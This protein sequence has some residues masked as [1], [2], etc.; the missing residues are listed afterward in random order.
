[1]NQT[2][3]G[4]TIVKVDGASQTQQSNTTLVNQTSQ[5]IGYSRRAKLGD[6]RST[7]RL[8]TTTNTNPHRSMT[9]LNNVGKLNLCL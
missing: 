5:Q 8:H 4:V 3:G 2:I 9:R 7:G 6:S 1:M